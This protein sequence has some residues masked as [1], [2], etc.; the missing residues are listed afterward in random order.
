MCFLESAVAVLVLAV[1]LLAGE[2]GA[3][4]TIDFGRGVL[5]AAACLWLLRTC[6]WRLAPELLLCV[7]FAGECVRDELLSAV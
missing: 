2:P 3:F 5:L 7:S 6:C 4:T 1:A